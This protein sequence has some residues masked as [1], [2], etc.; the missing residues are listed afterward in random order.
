MA[1]RPSR[2]EALPAAV[3]VPSVGKRVALCGYALRLS[4]SLATPLNGLPSFYVHELALF[5]GRFVAQ[6]PSAFFTSAADFARASITADDRACRRDLP[7]GA[8]LRG[9]CAQSARRRFSER[10]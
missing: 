5:L 1:D 7:A 9:V 4:P 6:T 3:S 10:L 8:P 2:A